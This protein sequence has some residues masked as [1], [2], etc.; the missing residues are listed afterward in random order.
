MHIFTSEKDAANFL[1]MFQSDQFIGF[2]A[3]RFV[4]ARSSS[5]T[6]ASSHENMIMT[7]ARRRIGM[8]TRIKIAWS[9]TIFI[10]MWLQAWNDLPMTLPTSKKKFYVGKRQK[11]T[12][13][14]KFEYKAF[15]ISVRDQKE[16]PRDIHSMGYKVA[17]CFFLT[18]MVNKGHEGYFV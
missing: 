5:S 17:N 6:L 9:W 18:G 15:D 8:R 10:A 3:M 2:L 14:A 11:I 12:S 13:F 1:H 7:R 16:K 4:S